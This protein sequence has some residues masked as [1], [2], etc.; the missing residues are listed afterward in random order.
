MTGIVGETIAHIRPRREH[1]ALAGLAAMFICTLGG[2]ASDSRSFATPES[3]VES[4]IAA[5]RAED[6]AELERI[7]GPDSHDLLYSGDE[8]A[9]AHSRANFLSLYDEKHA[10]KESGEGV[11]LEI[12]ET[13]WPFPIPVVKDADGWYFDTEAGSDEIITRRIGRNE[14]SAIQVCLAIV[15]AQREYAAADFAGNGWREYA[16]RFDSEPGTRNGLYWPAAPG[17]PE[18]PLG[19][20]MATAAAGGY[21]EGEHV[22]QPYHGYLYQILTSQ[23]AAAPDGK[24]DFIAQGHMIGGFGV[25]VW[26]A[27][28]ANSG[29]KTFIVSHLGVVYEKDLGD[30]TDSIARSMT[31]FNPDEGWQKSDATR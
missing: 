3:A 15:D 23:G 25:V 26:P 29:L 22:P 28:Y 30:E 7:F 27:N 6:S 9:D 5:V 20:F 13:D 19:E 17:E 12:G 1:F 2:C 11:I 10:L 8:V 14:L 31:A 24:M 21:L 4:F 16:Q 18:S